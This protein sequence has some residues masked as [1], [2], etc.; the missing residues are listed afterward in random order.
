MQLHQYHILLLLLLLLLLLIRQCL[1][2]CKPKLQG[3]V[4]A[5]VATDDAVMTSGR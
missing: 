2:C 1:D 5:N 4:A 3:Q